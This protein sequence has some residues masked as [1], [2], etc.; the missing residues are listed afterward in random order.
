MSVVSRNLK[1]TV[2]YWAVLDDGYGGVTVSAPV[3]IKARWEDKQI[4]F[5][6]PTGEEL[7]SEAVVYLFSDVGI[8][9][10]L[11]L[12]TSV[13]LDPIGNGVDVR[14]VRQFQKIPSV[15]ARIFERIA[16]L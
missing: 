14:P 13:D 11:F 8:N 12:G 6:S 16:F 5:Q 1:Q 15:N 4:L 10:L 9:G 3:T 7:T 2:T